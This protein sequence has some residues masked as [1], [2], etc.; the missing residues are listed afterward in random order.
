MTFIIIGIVGGIYL[1]IFTIE[2]QERIAYW[3]NLRLMKKYP[4]RYKNNIP[5]SLTCSYNCN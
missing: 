4:E 3:N 5:P 2:V 1:A